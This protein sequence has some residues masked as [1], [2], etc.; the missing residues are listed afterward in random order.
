MELKAMRL[1]W[2][3]AALMEAMMHLLAAGLVSEL[4]QRWTETAHVW[5]TRSSLLNEIQR[6]LQ[7]L[8]PT[9]RC[10]SRHLAKTLSLQPSPFA[11]C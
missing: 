2:S 11:L 5:L 1:N 9:R 7:L 4:F 8:T 10:G 3:R 6:I